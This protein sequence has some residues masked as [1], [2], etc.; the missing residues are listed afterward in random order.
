MKLSEKAIQFLENKKELYKAITDILGDKISDGY[1]VGFF[2]LSGKQDNT[3]WICIDH[4][5]EY[6]KFYFEEISFEELDNYEIRGK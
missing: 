3:I 2:D 4:K 1:K 5:Y 6:G